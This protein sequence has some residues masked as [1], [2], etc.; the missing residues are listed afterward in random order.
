MPWNEVS[1]MQERMRFII[2]AQLPE[3]VFSELCARYGIS[4][5][6]GYKWLKRFEKEGLGVVEER[7]SRPQNS[8][9]K[10]HE[11][12]ALRLLEL[13]NLHRY[14]GPKKLVKLLGNEG[15]GCIAPS[16]AGEILRR[17]GLTQRKKRRRNAVRAWPGSLTKPEYPN[18]IWTVDFKGWFRL[19]DGSKCHPL[20]V[21]DLHSRY[22][23]CLKGQRNE[24]LEVTKQSFDMLFAT[25]NIPKIIR[26]DN[27]HPFGGRNVYG[28]TRLSLDWVHKGIE[29]EFIDPGH[30]EQ[31]GSHERMHRT[32][33]NETTLPPSKNLPAQQRRFDKWRK[34]YNKLRPH[35][36][37]GQL[38]PNDIY[39]PSIRKPLSS[40]S[41]SYPG[42]YETRIVNKDGE[43]YFDRKRYFVSEIFKGSPLGLRR[44]ANDGLELYA[45][46]LYLG[47]LYPGRHDGLDTTNYGMKV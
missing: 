22:L 33:K 5:K 4:R 12:I 13:R 31:N 45:G 1:P 35:E 29:V 41:C 11:E 39:E 47:S 28:L 44:I 20:T 24:Q 25:S 40:A 32:L 27:G 8:P 2:E 6:T 43:I 42:H 17:A 18:H 9:T 23:L 46:E 34:E 3:V 15:V 14:W 10:V 26:V 38:C 7:S 19:N 16:T 21:M 37:L 30:P 36:S